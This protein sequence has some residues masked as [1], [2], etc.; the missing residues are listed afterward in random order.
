MLSV[1]PAIR[2]EHFLL[3]NTPQQSV[4]SIRYI[5]SRYLVYLFCV[6]AITASFNK[7]GE[8]YVRTQKILYLGTNCTQNTAMHHYCGTVQYP[9]T[10][11]FTTVIVRT[12]YLPKKFFFLRS[13]LRALSTTLVKSLSIFVDLPCL[14]VVTLLPLAKH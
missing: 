5:A 1:L 14:S 13:T 11:N 3:H 7:V 9:T 12:S 4:N 6:L 10:R 2:S 8:A